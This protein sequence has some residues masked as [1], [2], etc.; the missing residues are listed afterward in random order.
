MCIILLYFHISVFAYCNY[1]MYS[2]V[3]MY[4]CAYVYMYVRIMYALTVCTYVRSYIHIIQMFA[5]IFAGLGCCV[6]EMSTLKHAFTAKNIH[7]LMIRVVK[8]EVCYQTIVGMIT[9]IRTY[10]CCIV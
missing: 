3:H 8:G 9:Y 10:V 2:I 7:A 4:L 6:Y 5:Y 1:I